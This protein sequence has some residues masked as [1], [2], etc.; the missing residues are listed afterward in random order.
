MD[1]SRAINIR[2][3]PRVPVPAFFHSFL[4]PAGKPELENRAPEAVCIAD[5]ISYLPVERRRP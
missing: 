3:R 2:F 5:L 1:N 4:S